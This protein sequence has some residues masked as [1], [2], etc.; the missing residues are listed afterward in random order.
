MYTKLSPNLLVT[1]IWKQCFAA[2]LY[3]G[4][5]QL[6]LCTINPPALPFLFLKTS[7][8]CRAQT[9]ENPKLPSQIMLTRMNMMTLPTLKQCE[10]S[11][12]NTE[13]FDESFVF[14]E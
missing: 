5:S 7:Y 1:L 4:A 12:K 2:Y 9:S 13:Q 8:M 6:E 11:G 10:V 14:T 3:P